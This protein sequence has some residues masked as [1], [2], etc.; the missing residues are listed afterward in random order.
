M[1]WSKLSRPSDFGHADWWSLQARIYN[2]YTPVQTVVTDVLQHFV[3]NIEK[4][5]F[6]LYN[7]RNIKVELVLCLIPLTVEC[8]G[9]QHSSWLWL[10]FVHS[11]VQY[12]CATQHLISWSNKSEIGQSQTPDTFLR[13]IIMLIFIL[14]IFF[15]L[16]PD[17]SEGE[18]LVSV[19]P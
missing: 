16:C 9:I 17:H 19:A 10:L 15:F 6:L 13:Y 12:M 7:C 8:S 1:S 18:G 14:K 2:V 4:N 3:Q 11:Q 5:V